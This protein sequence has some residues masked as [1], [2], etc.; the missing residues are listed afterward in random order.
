MARTGAAWRRAL[1]GLFTRSVIDEQFWDDLEEALITSDVGPSTAFALVESV[2][3][4][5]R[6]AGIRTPAEVQSRLRSEMVATLHNLS[7][8]GQELSGDGKVVLLVV[9]VNGSGKTT[10]IGKLAYNAKQD[11]KRVILAAGD[12]FRAGAIDQIKV[13]AERLEVELVSH[14]QGSDPGAVAF[15]AMAA[16]RARGA[17]VVI[18]DTAGRL[19]T[20]HNLMEELKKV[21]RIVEREARDDFKQRVVLIIDGTVGQNGLVQARSFTEAVACDSVIL[22]KMDGTARGGVVLAIARELGLPVWCIGIGESP[23]D[24]A[25]FDART[26]VDTLLPEFNR[27][28]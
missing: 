5:S 27:D 6:R 13:W 20:Q 9:G 3:N 24:L 25:E 7:G 11:G 1:Y 26:F 15:D 2:R 17:D 21:R 16:A 14:R 18:V 8:K 10:T 4:L 22:T 19:H 12:T 28:H 23:E